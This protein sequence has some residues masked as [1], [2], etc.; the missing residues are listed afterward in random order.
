MPGGWLWLATDYEAYFE[1]ISALLQ[2]SDCLQETGR[3]WTGTRTNYEE[4]YLAQGR[5]I[6]RRTLK[7]E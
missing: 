6:Y 5:T 2:N 1:A 3:E 4:K 7:K